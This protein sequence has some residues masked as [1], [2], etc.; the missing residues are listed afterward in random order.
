M[1]YEVRWHRCR[2]TGAAAIGYTTAV[3]WAQSMWKIRLGGGGG[4]QHHLRWA[5]E[6]RET[7]GETATQSFVGRRARKKFG[8][9][10]D[11]GAAGTTREGAE[12]PF[13]FFHGIFLLLHRYISVD[14]KSMMK[15]VEENLM[16]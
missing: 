3:I 14:R 16:N 2:E 11:G 4:T 12:Q 1:S 8:E 10:K 13:L 15:Y 9:K 5:R 6:G 7:R